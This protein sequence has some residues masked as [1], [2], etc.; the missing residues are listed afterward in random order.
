MPALAVYKEM[1]TKSYGKI[2]AVKK[3]DLAAIADLA[4]GT[5]Q[6]Y[7]LY[8]PMSS[9]TLSEFISRTPAYDLDN[10][11]LLEEND[12]IV[13]CLGFWDWSK[14]TRV[15]VEKRNRKMQIVGL[16]ADIARSFVPMPRMPE[17]GRALRQMV[18]TPIA[19]QNPVQIAV[20]LRHVNN[21][22]LLRD[23]DYIFCICDPEHSFLK[24]LKGFFRIDTSLHIYVKLLQ[25]ELD[26]DNKPVFIS[27]IDL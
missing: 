11:F 7:E 18:L 4:N 24:G 8:E 2:R 27:G 16:L 25:E 1:D 23:I 5:W 26:L 21:I 12:E 20:L 6:G 9:D 22:A 14:A 19:F 13:A 15:M 10:M 3:E 17:P